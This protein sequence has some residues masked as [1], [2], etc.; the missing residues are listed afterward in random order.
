MQ[1]LSDANVNT[2]PKTP[3]K[4][5]FTIVKKSKPP[6]LR[7]SPGSPPRAAFLPTFSHMRPS[8]NAKMVV[9]NTLTVFSRFCR[10][11]SRVARY[12]SAQSSTSHGR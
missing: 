5:W 10:V 7:I 3:L 2:T 9:R 6:V 12:S 1:T 8:S 4:L 11:T